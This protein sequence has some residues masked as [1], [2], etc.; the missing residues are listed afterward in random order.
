MHMMNQ[1]MKLSL[2]LPLEDAVFT[3]KAIKKHRLI[4]YAKCFY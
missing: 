2:L 1:Q 3:T 4:F